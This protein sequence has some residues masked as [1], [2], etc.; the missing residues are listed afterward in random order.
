MIPTYKKI[1]FSVGA[2][3]IISITAFGVWLGFLSRDAQQTNIISDVSVEDLFVQSN[4]V[5]ANIPELFIAFDYPR[6][7]GELINNQITINNGEGILKKITF[8]NNSNI[9]LTGYEGK[10]LLG[11]HPDYPYLIY[12]GFWTKNN[13][14]FLTGWDVSLGMCELL[15]L[16][17]GSMTVTSSQLPWASARA[18]YLLTEYH[19]KFPLGGIAISYTVD[20]EQED[21]IKSIMKEWSKYFIMVYG[22]QYE[23]D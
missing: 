23:I 15:S 2:L 19:Q 13:D 16:G 4:L 11:T 3:F 20:E 10:T 9:V 22:E 7:W 5:H 1:L 17:Q 14:C 21:Y 8:S 6:Q 12:Q 18:I